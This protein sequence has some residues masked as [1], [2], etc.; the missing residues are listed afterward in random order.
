MSIVKDTQCF[1]LYAD[2][3]LTAPI[4]TEM[5]LYSDVE[6]G[7]NDG[8]TITYGVGGVLRVRWNYGSIAVDTYTPGASIFGTTNVV[9]SR[10]RLVAYIRADNKTVRVN[11]QNSY[12]GETSNISGSTSTTGQV[13]HN[14]TAN[15]MFFDHVRSAYSPLTNVKMNKV[16]V[17][18]TPE[19]HLGLYWGAS[20]ENSLL[21]GTWDFGTDITEGDGLGLP[22]ALYD[23]NS[24]TEDEGDYTSLVV[25]NSSIHASPV[26][27]LTLSGTMSVSKIL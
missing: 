10:T 16:S 22:V 23:F 13:I 25:P 3:E 7:S 6:V 24:L 8:L 21:A 5:T 4:T 2:F 11:T 14:N 12:N 15:T 18:S 17:W 20:I 9:G 1:A 27:D 26:G 19:L